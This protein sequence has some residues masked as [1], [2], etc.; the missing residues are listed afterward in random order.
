MR[1]RLKWLIAVDL[2]AQA[3]STSGKI[4]PQHIIA[5]THLWRLLP[6]NMN[7]KHNSGDNIAVTPLTGGEGKAGGHEKLALTLGMGKSDWKAVIRQQQLGKI[8]HQ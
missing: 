6:N 5:A 3:A 7:Y 2:T 4:S 1:R 8:T